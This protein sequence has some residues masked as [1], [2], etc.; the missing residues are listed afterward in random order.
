VPFKYD[1]TRLKEYQT[2]FPKGSLDF[3]RLTQLVLNPNMAANGIPIGQYASLWD[4]AINAQIQYRLDKTDA[5]W[6]VFKNKM[7]AARKL[8]AL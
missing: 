4:E 3:N 5:K 7:E 8:P 2:K 6:A 1:D